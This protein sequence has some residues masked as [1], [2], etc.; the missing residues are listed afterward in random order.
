MGP[1]LQDNQCLLN[2]QKERDYILTSN[3]IPVDR[4]GTA[5]ARPGWYL[6]LKERSL[7]SI[8]TYTELNDVNS[9]AGLILWYFQLH[10]RFQQVFKNISSVTEF[11][12]KQYHHANN[13]VIIAKRFWAKESLRKDS[14]SLHLFIHSFAYSS[15]NLLSTCYVSV[16]GLS[17]WGYA[18]K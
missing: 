7:S 4:V 5:G 6:Q 14:W 17:S 9:V 16:V 3:G 15:T 8:L 2:E 11:S 18:G 12:L 13:E 10:M 1:P